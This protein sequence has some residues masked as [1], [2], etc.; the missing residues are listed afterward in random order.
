MG[1]ELA[2]LGWKEHSLS[3]SPQGKLVTF[4]LPDIPSFTWIFLINWLHLQSWFLKKSVCLPGLLI[5]VENSLRETA[6]KEDAREQ[7]RDF[8]EGLVLNGG[9]TV[10]RVT[11]VTA[12]RVLEYGVWIIPVKSLLSTTWI[13]VWL[14]NWG[15]EFLGTSSEFLP[16]QDP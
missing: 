14:N 6:Q 16:K 5:G 4:T 1:C 11:E 10:I 15:I 3:F 8:Q 13:S 12:S 2:S 9:K 7:D